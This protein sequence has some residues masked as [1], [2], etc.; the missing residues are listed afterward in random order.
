MQKNKKTGLP[1]YI[2]MKHDGHFV[3]VISKKSAGPCI[4]IISINKIDPNPRQARNELGNIK[5]LMNSI[6]KKGILEPILV[7]PKND[8]YEIIAGERRF[9]ASKK[10]GLN[11][12]PCIEMNIEDAEAI[13][14]GLIENIQRKDLD[15]FEEADGLKVLYEIYGY[16]HKK[17]AEK[18]GKARSTITEI[19]NLSKIPIDVRN[20]CKKNNISSRS[21]LIEIA[22]QNSRI[23][24][25][26]LINEIKFRNLKREDT[27]ELSK[28]IKGRKI[29][30]KKF[31]YNYRP[32]ESNNFS[33]RIEFMKQKVKKFE[34][35]EVLER[36]L[37]ELREEL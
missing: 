18:L 31:V 7:R 33:L 10:L 1:N 32:K 25:I 11:E 8:K 22:K 6:N 36:V 34:I 27:R 17:I 23:D 2:H 37:K 5:E 3:D 15:V 12:I 30:R 13:E 14:I 28:K 9:I 26:N 4:R 35:V 20:I 29:I 24:M 19:I 16:S 21:T